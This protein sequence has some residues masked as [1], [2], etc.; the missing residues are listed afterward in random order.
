MVTKNHP[1]YHNKKD[2]KGFLWR[3]CV[4]GE[5]DGMYTSHPGILTS[6]DGMEAETWTIDSSS[7]KETI[8]DV[9]TSI[10]WIMCKLET[11]NHFQSHVIK[12]LK[13]PINFICQ[14]V[15]LVFELVSQVWTSCN[16]RKM[17]NWT[18]WCFPW[19]M[20]SVNYKWHWEIAVYTWTDTWDFQFQGAKMF[21]R[22]FRYDCQ[23]FMRKFHAILVAL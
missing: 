21:L 4:K 20:W 18:T 1:I 2:F 10:T 14:G 5:G 19:Q 8:D 6:I 3:K 15:S 17:K 9:I 12:F 22:I 16:V 11:R 7:Q 23:G 13:S